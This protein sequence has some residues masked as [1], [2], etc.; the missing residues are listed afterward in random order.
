VTVRLP[1]SLTR[2]LALRS[3]R[4]AVEPV[5]ASLV[6]GLLPGGSELIA[7]T[8]IQLR[9][10]RGA[11]TTFRSRTT[12]GQLF[13]DAPLNYRIPWRGRPSEGDYRVAGTIRP[14]KAAAIRFD[15]TVHFGSDKAAELTQETPPTGPA[16]PSSGTPAW[17]WAAL[18]LGAALLSG[19][20]LAVWRLA[21]R[22]PAPGLPRV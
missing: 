3:V 10:S 12:L 7:S 2:S 13:P 20:S 6:L 22:P 9:V 17:V 8:R 1:G 18:G 16:Q 21:R 5:G 19:L 15:R 4:L 14:A 11:R